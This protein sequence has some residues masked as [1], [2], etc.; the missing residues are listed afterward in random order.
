MDANQI[1][2]ISDASLKKLRRKY[3][4]R[5]RE[6]RKPTKMIEEEVSRRSS[7]R[8]DDFHLG[9]MVSHVVDGKMMTGKIVEKDD[10]GALIERPDLEAPVFI[11]YFYLRPQDESPHSS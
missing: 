9:Q 2:S 6:I 5:A 8:R 11:M 3:Q 1:V 10:F 7:H 4:K